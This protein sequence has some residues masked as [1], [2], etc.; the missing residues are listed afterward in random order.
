MS[1]RRAVGDI[2]AAVWMLISQGSLEEDG[3]EISDEMSNHYETER[4]DEENRRE[5]SKT[6]IGRDPVLS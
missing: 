5:R 4:E 2:V 1:L 3:Q 6:G